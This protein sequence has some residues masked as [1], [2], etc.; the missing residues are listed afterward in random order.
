MAQ[1]PYA[2]DDM[3]G[4]SVAGVAAAVGGNGIGV[5][6]AAP[7]AQIAG[8]RISFGS[9][10]EDPAVTSTDL[11][12]AF[13][14]KSGITQDGQY[15]G[16]AAIH[17]KNNSWGATA[18]FMAE[19]QNVLDSIA[20]AARNNVIFVFSAGNARGT[21]TE[22]A[23]SQSRNALPETI[24]VAAF[25]ADGKYSYY[26]SFGSSV[27][28]TAASNGALVST[29]NGLADVGIVTTDRTGTDGYAVGD[30]TASFGGTSSSAPLIS[31]IVALGKEA[32]SALDS[33]WAKHS[34]ATTSIVVDPTDKSLSTGVV[35]WDSTS[36]VGRGWQTN[37]AGL[38]FNPNYG[39]GLADAGA[40]V[41]RVVDIAYV[42][43]QT[44]YTKTVTELNEKFY[45]KQVSYD[46]SS[47]SSG[48]STSTL[49]PNGHVVNY[50]FT[51]GS[52][53]ITQ[54]LENIVLSVNIS[55]GKAWKDL[56]IQITSPDGT[57]SDVYMP[58]MAAPT[59]EQL[60][61]IEAFGI[62]D[63]LKWDFVSN[64][65][66][67]ES[68]IG[69]WTVTFRNFGNTVMT[70]NDFSLVFNQGESVLEQAGV[71]QITKNISAHALAIDNSTTQFVIPA[72]LTF[73]VDDSTILN[74]GT[75][76]VGGRIAQTS[77]KG[78][79][80][81]VKGGTLNLLTGGV[82]DAK[83]GAILSGGT[84]NLGGNLNTP[85]GTTILETT[86]VDDTTSTANK[87][88]NYGLIMTGGT[89]N[90][91]DNG[92]VGTGILQAGGAVNIAAGK[93]L[94]TPK[95]D[96]QGVFDASN[97]LT[98]TSTLAIA[99]T[100]SGN[101]TA[102]DGAVVT[103]SGNA[104]IGG[105]LTLTGAATATGSMAQLNIA[106]GSNVTVSGT[107]HVA[108]GVMNVNAS[109]FKSGAIVVSGGTL[110]ITPAM[111]IE[112]PVTQFGGRI[113]LGDSTSFT[114]TLTLNGGEFQ[115][116]TAND[117]TIAAPQLAIANSGKF[118]PGGSAPVTLNVDGN[119]SMQGGSL[120]IDYNS[121]ANDKLVVSGRT[122]I[123]Y[124]TI[125]LAASAAPQVSDIGVKRVTILE[126]AGGLSGRVYA[127]TGTNAYTER[128]S[129]D[130]TATYEIPIGYKFHQ[131][132]E[133]TGELV[134]GYDY[135]SAKFIN[136][137][138]EN[139]RQIG[140]A[141]NDVEAA[142]G[143]NIDDNALLLAINQL[144]SLESLKDAY[145]K[146]M[147][148]NLMSLSRSAIK[149]ATALTTTF[150][151]RSRDMR[152]GSI[153]PGS[154]WTNYLFEENYGFNFTSQPL[155]ASTGFVP[156]TGQSEL[157]PIT[158]WMNGGASFWKGDKSGSTPN[159]KSTQY[160]GTIG[161]DYR[162]ESGMGRDA[163]TYDIG[164]ILGYN[165]TTDKI[166]N[167]GSRNELD[168]I[169]MGAYFST[170]YNG[171]YLNALGAYSIN[172]YDFKREISVAGLESVARSKPD[173]AQY[174]GFLGGGYEWEFKD[175]AHGPTITLQ[176]SQT[177][178]DGYTESGAGDQDLSVGDQDYDSLLTS[179]GYRISTRVKTNFA[180]LL[181]EVRFAWNHEF[182]DDGKDITSTM[183]SGLPFTV[184]TGDGGRN[185]ATIGVGL[186]MLLTET[187]SLSVDYDATLF[188][189]DMDPQHTV[190]AMLRVSF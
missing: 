133:T 51:L 108:N 184:K 90:A 72:G 118:S 67:G 155:V 49:D 148:V 160:T 166:G 16:E 94:S 177:K 100:F 169:A 77:F 58:M 145:G 181:P 95:L 161:L 34:F 28:V 56:L 78:N 79:Q 119:L 124:G 24:N 80:L 111:T 102:N 27:F 150:D 88:Y 74:G 170:A 41:K 162:W 84:L 1:R 65:F 2:S 50:K 164:L 157:Y 153:Q 188:Q 53:D 20:T 75:I 132:G 152:R 151:R 37:G 183:A 93:K 66:W 158:L 39:F 33:R 141:L 146:L 180:T 31:G 178:V 167:S 69:E 4:T 76:E 54:A 136:Q 159:T 101:L 98:A 46:D 143:G 68:G 57:V 82:I 97:N 137:L 106:S 7:S 120:L 73:T 168:G 156:Y 63:G 130:G 89:L 62:S 92:S 174:V 26:S 11:I 15:T 104:V 70:L 12:N 35:N 172:S 60:A 81:T 5:T 127:V 64:N 176:Y 25:G 163:I 173:G 19:S 142:S 134:V 29:G 125:E 135:A 6:G 126:S 186:T 109:S 140:Y 105:N 179:I 40:F 189:K 44:V 110:A 9:S 147:P 121:S 139:E 128:T 43:Q 13:L 30:Y 59:E 42:T 3:H 91:G 83:R 10:S 52:N 38:Q 154:I 103:A 36:Y 123:S 165:N 18:P 115:T 116:P 23:A 114:Q 113:T 190:N 187:V 17:I 85:S 131:S 87:T 22:Q 144:T 55:S 61:T 48:S 71:Q 107:V 129:L 45:P 182:L 8:M 96:V 117:K 47:S 185:Y 32:N 175:W 86:T 149:Q 171:F 21:F 14:W 122:N 112:A 99:G 138:T